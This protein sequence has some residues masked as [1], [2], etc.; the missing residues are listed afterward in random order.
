MKKIEIGL[1]GIQPTHSFARTIQVYTQNKT[2]PSVHV[3]V[4]IY[5]DSCQFLL[6]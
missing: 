4:G 6:S 3:S 1:I 5:V 2:G